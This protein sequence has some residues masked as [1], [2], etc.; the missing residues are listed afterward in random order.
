MAAG[1]FKIDLANI[2][3][4]EIFIVW[5][6]IN[7]I[8]IKARNLKIHLALILAPDKYPIFRF[9]DKML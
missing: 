6:T 9:F 2:Q 8:V 7:D 3:E 4:S 5:Q 1:S